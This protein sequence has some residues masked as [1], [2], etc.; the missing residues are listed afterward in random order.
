MLLAAKHRFIMH[1]AMGSVNS[2][3]ELFGRLFDWHW[4]PVN[5]PLRSGNAMRVTWRTPFAPYSAL[6]RTQLRMSDYSTTSNKRRSS[7]GVSVPTWLS[8]PG[9]VF[10]RHCHERH[11]RSKYEP[12]AE[13]VELVHAT[14]NYARVRFSTGRETTVP[15]RDI[16]PMKRAP[17][18][19]F[20]AAN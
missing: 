10:L 8:S 3:T 13:E 12:V 5:Y 11:A 4:H 15:S 16:A 19:L 1:L 6:L 9:L 17:A 18:P 2:I 20:D 14:P 7:F